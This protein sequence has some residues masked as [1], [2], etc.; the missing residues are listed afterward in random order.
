M[1]V[2]LDYGRTGLEVNLPD[3]NVIGPLAIKPAQ[4]LAQPE[5]VLAKALASPTGTPPLAE[6]AR[7]RKNA[8]SLI[9][10]ITRPVPNKLILPPGLKILESSGIAPKPILLLVATGLSRPTQSRELVE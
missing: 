2:K 8:R 9:C 1:R 10:D 4:P 6:L 5:Q 7:G 3:Q